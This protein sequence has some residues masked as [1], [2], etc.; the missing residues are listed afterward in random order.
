[1]SD[2]EDASGVHEFKRLAVWNGDHNVELQRA[3][4]GELVK[5]L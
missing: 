4:N 5:K 3:R 1:M 2:D